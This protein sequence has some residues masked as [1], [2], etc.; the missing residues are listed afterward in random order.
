ME[1]KLKAQCM[2]FIRENA[3]ESTNANRELV[4]GMQNLMMIPIKLPANVRVSNIEFIPDT[5]DLPA[6]FPHLPTTPIKQEPQLTDWISGDI[7]PTI[8]GV[9][10]RD[11]SSVIPFETI[12]YALFKNGNWATGY[13]KVNSDS[14][15]LASKVDNVSKSQNLPWRGLSSNPN[16]VQS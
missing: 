3:T 5:P 2:E 6:G 14:I 12:G 8:D 16:E 10:E 1:S 7:L 4:N 11:Y 9:Y 13:R 15:L